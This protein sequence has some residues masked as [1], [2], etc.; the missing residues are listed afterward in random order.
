MLNYSLISMLNY[1][2]FILFDKNVFLFIFSTKNLFFNQIVIK[3]GSG[4]NA[5][6]LRRF[7]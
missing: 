4:T 5:V 2:S 7:Q 1:P 3:F 6:K